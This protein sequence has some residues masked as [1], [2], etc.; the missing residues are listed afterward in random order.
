MNGSLRWTTGWWTARRSTLVVALNEDVERRWS[1][2]R[3]RVLVESNIA[4]DPVQLQELSANAPDLR[5]GGYR[6]ALF[7]GR[8]IPWKGLLLAVESLRFAPRWKLVIF[9]EGPDRKA[10]EDLADRLGLRDRLDFRGHVSRNEVLGAFGEADALLFPSFHDSAGWAVGE[11]SSLG[12]PVI[13]L[14]AGGPALQAGCNGHVVA[15]HPEATLAERLGIRLRDLP[16]RGE[17]DLRMSSSRL[18]AVLQDWYSAQPSPERAEARD[19]RHAA[20]DREP[21]V[22]A[23]CLRVRPLLGPI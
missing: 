2:G 7:V 4:L 16:P 8:L 21:S 3:N 17:P 19:G 18:D 14:D 1:R 22:A 23:A 12:C 10:A 11:A 6:V 20:T 5:A 13:C 15:I 9:G